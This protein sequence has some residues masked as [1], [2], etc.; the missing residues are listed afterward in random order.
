MTMGYYDTTALPIYAYLHANGAPKYV[1][2]DHFFQ[3]AFGG[4]FLNH[5]FLIAAA[6]PVVHPADYPVVGNRTHAV[7]SGDGFPTNNYTLYKATPAP[8]D[9]PL[10]QECGLTTTISTLACGDYG[11]NTLLPWYQPTGG[12]SPKIH[13]I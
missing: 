11:V 10:T 3:A 9:G 12:F 5:Q 1:I 6:A 4:S 8:V 2:A 13:P 7:L